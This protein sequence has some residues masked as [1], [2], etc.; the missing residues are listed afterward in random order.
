[1]CEDVPNIAVQKNCISRT[2]SRLGLIPE[3]K[4]VFT[5][6]LEDLLKKVEETTLDKAEAIAVVHNRTNQIIHMAPLV[7]DNP[8]HVD[9]CAGTGE[10]PDIVTVEEALAP[11]KD[12]ENTNRFLFL[13]VK[14]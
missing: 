10:K 13:K 9:Q 7:K 2:L 3:D 14:Q 1:M 12:E 4:P 8:G 5:P 11:Y 6:S